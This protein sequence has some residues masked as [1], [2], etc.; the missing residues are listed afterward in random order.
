M[1]LGFESQAVD[2]ELYQQTCCE[3]NIPCFQLQGVCVSP[4]ALLPAAGI[5]TALSREQRFVAGAAFTRGPLLWCSSR[6]SHFWEWPSNSSAWASPGCP[7]HAVLPCCKE[8]LAGNLFIK[9][10]YKLLTSFKDFIWLWI[11]KLCCQR[12]LCSLPGCCSSQIHA[13]LLPLCTCAFHSVS[14]S[15]STLLHLTCVWIC[16]FVTPLPSLVTALSKVSPE[17]FLISCVPFLAQK[18]KVNAVM[19]MWHSVISN[20]SAK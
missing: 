11:D 5:E 17:G 13:V 2:P 8:G 9:V 6:C 20:S 3:L 16:C 12:F 7:A 1:N 18:L 14:R 10:R 19:N 15:H 4:P